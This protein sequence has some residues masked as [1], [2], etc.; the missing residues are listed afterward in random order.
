MCTV[1]Y[2]A[3]PLH[4]LYGLGDVPL[5]AYRAADLPV[6]L[7][8]PGY[9]AD[10][11]LGDDAILYVLHVLHQRPQLQLALRPQL[12]HLLFQVI[13]E[14]RDVRCREET[15]VDVIQGKFSCQEVQVVLHH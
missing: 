11:L 1:N 10:S 4:H 2:S 6:D 8:H 14:S 5:H 15:R 3:F 9:L 13:Q 12:P 7:E